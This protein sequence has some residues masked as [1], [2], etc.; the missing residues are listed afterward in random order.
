MPTLTFGALPSDLVKW[1]ANPDY[2]RETV[3]LLTG[4]NYPFGA[5]LGK[6]TASGKFKLSPDTGA[7]GSETAVAVL[8]EARDATSGDLEAIVLRRGPS[9]VSQGM[10]QVDASVNDTTKRTAKFNQLAAVGIVARVTA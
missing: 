4:T 3:T 2:T 9:I 10:L 1:E 5:V 6:V 8:L 7:D